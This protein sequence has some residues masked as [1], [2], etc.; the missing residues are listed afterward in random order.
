MKVL[1]LAAVIALAAAAPAAAQVQ[2]MLTA[3]PSQLRVEGLA[4]PLGDVVLR[5][6][7]G[8]PFSIWTGSIQVFTSTLLANRTNG[9]MLEE[10]ALEQSLSGQW[11]VRSELRARGLTAN[12]FVLE[13]VAAGFDENG[14]LGLRLSGVRAEAAQEVLLFISSLGNPQLLLP[15]PQVVVGRA[16]GVS[17]GATSQAAAALPTL[18]PP[19]GADFGRLMSSGIP[20]V[21]TRVTEGAA[22]V[23]HKSANMFETG[24]RIL[25]RYQNTPAGAQV[26]A[27]A[28][29]AGSTALQPTGGGNLGLPFS[30][31]LY[32]AQPNGALLL[33]FVEGAKPDG[34]GGSLAFQPQTGINALSRVLPA[35]RDG[36]VPYAVYEVLD[37]VSGTLESAQFPAWII[38]T[39]NCCQGVI[40]DSTVSL[41]P[42][43]KERGVS[44]D[45]PLPRFKANTAGPD[46]V[47][48]NDCEAAYLPQLFVR[49]VSPQE[50]TVPSGSGPHYGYL[51]VS[52]EGGGLLR[53]LA[54]AA[55][56]SGGEWL[57]TSPALGVNRA[58]VQYVVSAANLAPGVYTGT[59]TLRAV[60]S[61]AEFS[62][63]VRVT[64]TAPLPPPE[65]APVVRDVVKAGN[66]LPGPVAPGSLAIVLGENFGS[67]STVRVGGLPAQLVSASVNELLIEIP[68]ALNPASGRAPVI[69]ELGGRRSA[70][71]GVEVAAV[72][73]AVLFAVNEDG[74]ERNTA[75]NPVLSG[76]GL[77]LSVTGLALTNGLVSVRIHDRDITKLLDTSVLTPMMGAVLISFV[78]PD[79]LPAMSTAVLVCGSA[80]GGPSV[81]AEPFDVF[82][83]AP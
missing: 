45:A 11:Q 52:N 8:T 40:V 78:V 29:V 19:E 61:N 3:N 6:S 55:T 47:L 48:L 32:L 80:G 15:T 63:P 65:P 73:P 81:C 79:D 71:W 9:P 51:I 30:G 67:A 1:K 58:T 59:V 70:P 69:V 17:L 36:G 18:A 24:T 10:V 14:Q 21:T 28:A 5:C 25:V 42:V 33:S 54:S 57:R 39:G 75:D 12:S 23:F 2:C 34:S 38:A 31:G 22:A 72:A 37:S 68:P 62:F 46:C 16:L 76:R 35:A 82:L 44:S 53:W 20:S 41:A 56:D 4:E 13:N 43:S 74:G 49:S 83:T 60:G 50:F 66:R 64:V 77:L 27:P 26:L 7:G